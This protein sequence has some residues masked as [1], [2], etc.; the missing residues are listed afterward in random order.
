MKGGK[1]VVH[2]TLATKFQSYN[3]YAVGKKDGMFT[4]M[5]SR[6]LNVIA[7]LF[8]I[9]LGFGFLMLLCSIMIGAYLYASG[10]KEN[11]VLGKDRIVRGIIGI[12][13]ISGALIGF[14]NMIFAA[15]NSF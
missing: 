9:G 2:F 15:V 10:R 12:V 14:L 8:Q 1:K 7:Q 6:A 11:I 3:K 13:A 4:D 5:T